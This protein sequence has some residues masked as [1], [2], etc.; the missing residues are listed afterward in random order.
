MVTDMGLFWSELVETLPTNIARQIGY[1]D[2]VTLRHQSDRDLINVEPAVRT[3]VAEATYKNHVIAATLGS[4]SEVPSHPI[5]AVGSMLNEFAM[6][7]L[8]VSVL[9]A[10]EQKVAMSIHSIDGFETR[11]VVNRNK[12]RSTDNQ[13]SV[14]GK[15]YCLCEDKQLY[16][17]LS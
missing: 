5:L 6:I 7:K 4:D 9:P 1:S 15:R 8:L 10:Q 3:S 12:V 11:R 17:T 2:C 16:F 14:F 13:R